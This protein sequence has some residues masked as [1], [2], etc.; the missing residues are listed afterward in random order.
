MRR[1]A[2]A[3]VVVPPWLVCIVAARLTFAAISDLRRDGYLRD[4]GCAV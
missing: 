4:W 1:L 2:I 3:L